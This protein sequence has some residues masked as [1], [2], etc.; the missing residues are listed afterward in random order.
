MIKKFAIALLLH[1][2]GMITVKCMYPELSRYE[3]FTESTLGILYYV[4]VFDWLDR[5]ISK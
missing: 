3:L 5:H 4:V 2:V 1:I